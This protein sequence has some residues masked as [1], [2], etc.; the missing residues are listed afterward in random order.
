L[1]AG[2][3]LAAG[4]WAMLSWGVIIAA[5]FVDG[6]IGARIFCAIVLFPVGALSAR[7]MVR[8]QMG[9]VAIG[10]D[11]VRIAGLVRSRSV[12]LDEVDRFVI[13]PD[14]SFGMSQVALKRLKGRRYMLWVT[15]RRHQRRGCR[16]NP[17]GRPVGLR[18][19]GHDPELHCV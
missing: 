13:E 9:F 19:F 2:I 12:P 15:G 18:P 1:R 7:I 14:G 3:T 6:P 8:A 10:P 5:V 4:L 11:N 16:V 17:W